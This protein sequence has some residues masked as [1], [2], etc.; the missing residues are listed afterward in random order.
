M[1]RFI[2][3]LAALLGGRR[4][5]D[6]E[7]ED[8]IQA[9]LEMAQREGVARGLSPEQA[10]REARL[11]FGGIEQVKEAHRERRSFGWIETLLRDFRYG[12]AG[13]R[14][15]PGFSAVVVGVLALGMG[16][17][18]GMFSV[19]DAVLLKPLPFADP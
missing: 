11:R 17:N 14:R 12:L 18:V 6:R 5:L 19:V 15:A 3:R 16:A 10:R 7:L 9:H 2:G 8:E 1:R 4:R 13:V